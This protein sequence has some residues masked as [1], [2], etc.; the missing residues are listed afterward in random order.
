MLVNLEKINRQG[1]IDIVDK[2]S[3]GMD[4][5]ISYT[6][7]ELGMKNFDFVSLQKTIRLEIVKLFK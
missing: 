5:K 4:A 3:L 1:F 2:L 7:T 6:V